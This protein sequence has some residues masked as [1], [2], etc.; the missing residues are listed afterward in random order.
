MKYKRFVVKIGTAILGAAMITS[1]FSVAGI[2]NTVRADVATNSVLML[3]SGKTLDVET[4]ND[5]EL[6]VPKIQGKKLK[7]LPGVDDPF[8]FKWKKC[9]II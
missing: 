1:A 6:D 7:D 9:Y 3:N 2:E 4:P 5:V 8:I